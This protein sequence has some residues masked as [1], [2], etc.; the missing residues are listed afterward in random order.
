M[1]QRRLLELV[2]DYDCT[3]NYH[4][5]KANVVADVL[6]RNTK[7]KLGYFITKQEE[8]IR[9]FFTFSLK[10]VLPL[11]IVSGFITTL[12]ATPDLQ[13]RTLGA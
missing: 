3:I 13:D 2:K 10:I 6:S 4:P 1:R 12:V 5:G 11:E 8:L 7:A 9:D